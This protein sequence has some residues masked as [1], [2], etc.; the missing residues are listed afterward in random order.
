[1][2]AVSAVP[3]AEHLARVAR[4][5]A[6]HGPDVA[7]LCDACVDG[8]PG[9]EGAGLAVMT[10]L[11]AQQVRYASNQVSARVEELQVVLGEGPCLEAFAGG[12]PVLASD[13]D[14]PYWLEQWP[15]FTPAAVGAGA[16][17]L[18]ALPLQVGAV[19]L[20]VIDLYR[21][22]PGVLAGDELAE[23]LAFADAAT[24]LLLAEH[25]PGG[26]VP[27]SA[28]VFSHRAVVTRPPAWSAP[29][30]GCRSPT[31]FCG[32]GPMRT[33][34]SAASTMWPATWSPGG[35]ASTTPTTTMRVTSR[36]R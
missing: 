21:P 22:A 29:S 15:V 4:L 13:L 27:G 34:P 8:L 36:C 12:R 7:R 16:R 9:V 30:W 31:P 2:T 10:S 25:L 11:P 26:Q 20:G 32:C 28:Q 3:G 33:R 14:D 18:F 1:M 23:A 24:E 35:C 5:V 6:A 17:A 19:C